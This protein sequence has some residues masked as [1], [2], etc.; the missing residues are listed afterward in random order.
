MI[1]IYAEFGILAAKTK[2]VKLCHVVLNS[3]DVEEQ[4]G[5]IAKAFGVGIGILV[6]ALTGDPHKGAHVAGH[7]LEHGHKYKCNKCGHE[8]D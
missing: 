5:F 3:S 8:F 7:S 6:G 2:E 1:V 4:G